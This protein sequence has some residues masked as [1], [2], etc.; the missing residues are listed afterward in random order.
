MTLKKLGNKQLCH[1]L[2]LFIVDNLNHTTMQISANTLFHFTKD[3]DT[4]ISI[5]KTKFYPRLCLEPDVASPEKEPSWAIPMVCFCDI[6][7]SNITKHTEIYG[8]YAIGITKDWA[9]KQ[10]VTPILY[11]HKQSAYL[12]QLISSFRLQIKKDQLEDHI[13]SKGFTELLTAYFMMKPYKGY[14]EI[15]GKRKSVCFYDE[16]EWR[17]VPPICSSKEEI[18]FL[19][20]DMLKKEKEW[21]RINSYNERYGVSF[22][23]DSINYIIVKSEDEILPL[24]RELQSIKGGSY[25]YDSV[26][27]L[28]TRILSME[29]IKE[30]F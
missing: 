25:T 23:P 2:A 12:K 9:M 29:R 30:D 28:M 24:C 3:Y 17:Y 6:P 10:G 13:F 19:A 15:N 16:R 11:V 7:L 8:N 1:Y 22:E 5:L 27:I 20:G 18:N 21:I 26:Q 14:Q 4:L